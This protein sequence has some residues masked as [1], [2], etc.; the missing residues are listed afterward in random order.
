MP[1]GST[2]APVANV[3]VV[4]DEPHVCRLIEDILESDE[5]RCKSVQSGR[6]AMRLL[7]EE[8]FDVIILDL[9]MPGISGMDLLKFISSW[10]FPT[11]AICITGVSTSRTSQ[12]ALASGAFDF[13]EKP[14][15]VPRLIESVRLA[16]RS[17]F[18]IVGG[19]GKSALRS[20]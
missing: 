16:A 5:F 1:K 6:E 3:L 2:M 15:D 17:C 14:F 18:D 9:L 13:F 8:K 11:Q 4:D 20:A 7:L 12:E 19:G 10:G